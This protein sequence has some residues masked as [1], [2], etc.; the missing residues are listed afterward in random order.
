[1]SRSVDHRAG[2]C[3]VIHHDFTSIRDAFTYFPEL[4]SLREENSIYWNTFG[5]G[6]W[7]VTSY[8]LIKEIYQNSEFFTSDSFDP[9]DADPQYRMVPLQINPPEHIEY[10]HAVNPWFAPRAID[11]F[12]PVVRDLAASYIRPLVERGGCDL[13]ADFGIDYPV[14]VLLGILG[15]PQSDTEEFVAN[16]ETFFAGLVN[17]DNKD[18]TAAASG[19]IHQYFQGI[20]ADRRENP[21]DPQTDFV[22]YLLGREVFERPLTDTELLDFCFTVAIGGVDTVRSTLGYMFHHLATHPED[23]QRLVADPSLVPHAVEECLRAYSIVI[24]DARK[25]AQDID[26]HGAQLKKGQMVQLTVS[27]A[28]RD[29]RVYGDDSH[30]FNLDRTRFAHLGFGAG[31]HRCLGSHLARREV[32]VAV[33]EFHKLIPEYSLDPSAPIRERGWTASLL[34]LPLTWETK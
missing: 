2:T 10:R 33:E 27:A 9:L 18:E 25:V 5:P 8:D 16:A 32:A 3:P 21:R 30:E 31:T 20:L 17:P 7:V 26:F 14:A 29:P 19:R 4:D 13:I 34:S 23:R 28:N 6:Y 12:T 1:M 11:K 15:L 22:S 24:S